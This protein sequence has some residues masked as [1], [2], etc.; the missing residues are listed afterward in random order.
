M[1]CICSKLDSYGK[2]VELGFLSEADFL[3]YMHTKQLFTTGKNLCTIIVMSLLGVQQ[4][5]CI[6]HFHYRLIIIVV[7]CNEV[8]TVEVFCTCPFTQVIL[9]M[10]RPT[11]NFTGVIFYWGICTFTQVLDLWATA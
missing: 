1:Y 4:T 2:T 6:F 9:K 11:Y 3:Q 10:N 5:K 8:A 7:D